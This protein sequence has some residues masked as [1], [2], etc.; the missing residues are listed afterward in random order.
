MKAVIALLCV[1]SFAPWAA[2][3]APVAPPAAQACQADT[4]TPKPT[5]PSSLVPRADSGSHVYGAP[6]Q[7]KI[8]SRV[9]RKPH[10]PTAPAH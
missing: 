1:L 7:S 5:K 6:I 10:K 3:A 8:L 2:R 9:K 4:D